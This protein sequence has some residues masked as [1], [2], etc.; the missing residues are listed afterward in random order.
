[1][2]KYC[3]IHNYRATSKSYNT[4]PFWVY[5]ITL[6]PIPELSC[7]NSKIII[8]SQC[9]DGR[10]SQNITS[11]NDWHKMFEQPAK[12]WP[13]LCWNNVALLTDK[14]CVVYQTLA[15]KQ[16]QLYQLLSPAWYNTRTKN[17]KFTNLK[18]RQPFANL[19]MAKIFFPV[20]FQLNWRLMEAKRANCNNHKLTYGAQH[21]ENVPNQ[22][23]LSPHQQ[24]YQDEDDQSYLPRLHIP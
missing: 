11:R 8:V 24:H 5:S 14:L 9:Q 13:S 3:I 23:L 18:F 20:K 17:A 12:R 7:L 21:R 1:M 4:S 10:N 2:K 6:F 19:K 15:I 16:Y 22:R